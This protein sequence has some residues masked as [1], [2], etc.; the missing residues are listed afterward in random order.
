MN[1]TTRHRISICNDL[2]VFDGYLHVAINEMGDVIVSSA[3]TNGYTSYTYGANMKVTG[4]I[5]SCIQV[6]SDS[7]SRG[8]LCTLLYELSHKYL[9]VNPH[10]RVQYG[11]D[12]IESVSAIIERSPNMVVPFIN[13]QE[14]Q[15]G[16]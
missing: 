16:F 5:I 1:K 3:D 13:T 7:I 10:T 2:S 6:L 9:E 14:L 12:A 15:V 8:K 4:G 11:T